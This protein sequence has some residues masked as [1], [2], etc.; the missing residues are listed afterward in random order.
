[1]CVCVFCPRKHEL[2]FGEAF[3]V[4]QKGAAVQLLIHVSVYVFEFLKLKTVDILESVLGMINSLQFCPNFRFKVTD[5]KYIQY[6]S[7]LL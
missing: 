1:M 3:S 6:K 5:A 2:T 4:A 7:V